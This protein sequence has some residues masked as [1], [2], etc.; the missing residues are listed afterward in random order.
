MARY[1]DDKTT[2]SKQDIV[3][4]QQITKLIRK[5]FKS[6]NIPQIKI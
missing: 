5:Y 2:Y 1:P 3:I 4:A 6:V